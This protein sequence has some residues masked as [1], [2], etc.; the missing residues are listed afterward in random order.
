MLCIT[1]ALE[2]S[3][4]SKDAPFNWM[5]ILYDIA[6]G[7]LHMHTNG[8]V[9]G[10]LQPFNIVLHK[11]SQCIYQPVFFNL[12]KA[13]KLSFADN[14]NRC[15]LINDLKMFAQLLKIV[16][17]VLSLESQMLEKFNSILRLPT[18]CDK[19][20]QMLE[21]VILYLRTIIK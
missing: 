18:T 11:R 3:M 6:Q 4:K 16:L 5:S 14:E 7:L 17:E 12:E 20:F 8:F 21:N 15:L 2:E 19:Q 1:A 10:N 13:S 9:H